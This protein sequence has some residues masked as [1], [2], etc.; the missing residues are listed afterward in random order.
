MLLS[1]TTYAVVRSNATLPGANFPSVCRFF[2]P[3]G[4]KRH[5]KDEK[6]VVSRILIFFAATGKEYLS[7]QLRKPYR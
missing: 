2:A 4:E 1:Y 3:Q 6:L 5:T 7:A